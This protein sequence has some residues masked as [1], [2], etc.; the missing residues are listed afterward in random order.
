MLLVGLT[1]RV[2]SWARPRRDRL[3]CTRRRD[4][5]TP[6]AAVAVEDP[7]SPR[8]LSPS[9]SAAGRGSSRSRCPIRCPPACPQAVGGTHS[10]LELPPTCSRRR[11]IP[12]RDRHDQGRPPLVRGS[13]ADVDPTRRLRPAGRACP[14]CLERR[15][16]RRVVRGC[17]PT[18]C[19]VRRNRSRHCPARVE[20]PCRSRGSEVEVGRSSQLVFAGIGVAHH[21][22]ARNLFWNPKVIVA[23]AYLPF[24]RVNSVF[25]DPS[26]YGR[27]LMIAILCRARDR[28]ARPLAA[29]SS[30]SRPQSTICMRHLGQ[31][32][33]LLVLPVPSLPA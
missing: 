26:I 9:C 4:R 18:S 27:F 22:A 31:A 32:S 2:R 3:C 1:P 23:N 29:G 7:R 10:Q 25:W 20:P 33:V 5:A 16:A 12:D 8:S 13:G 15:R 24:Y 11:Q 28:D 30:R 19:T 6:W 14:A 21:T 17:S